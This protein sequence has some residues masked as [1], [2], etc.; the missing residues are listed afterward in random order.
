MASIPAPEIG[1][2]C[3]VPGVNRII[4]GGVIPTKSDFGVFASLTLISDLRLFNLQ[5]AAGDIGT[6][7][8]R[9]GLQSRVATVR[10]C[11]YTRCMV[12]RQN[13]MQFSPRCGRRDYRVGKTEQFLKPNFYTLAL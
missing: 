11:V 3:S 13:V 6:V 8:K 2:L 12:M 4:C 1:S 9:F 10:R 7:K 5:N